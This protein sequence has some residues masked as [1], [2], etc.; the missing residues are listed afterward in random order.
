MYR[1]PGVSGLMEFLGGIGG[2]IAVV[3]VVGSLVLVV[4]YSVNGKTFEC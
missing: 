3:A 4:I 2:L 1:C